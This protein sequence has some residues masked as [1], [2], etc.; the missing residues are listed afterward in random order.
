MSLLLLDGSD[1]F[2]K[3]PRAGMDAGGQPV[4]QDMAIDSQAWQISYDFAY[5]DCYRDGG[6]K[7]AG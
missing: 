7:K 3:S 2:P 5:L 6:T 4:P 1:L